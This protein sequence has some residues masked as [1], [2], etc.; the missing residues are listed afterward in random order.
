MTKSK[1]TSKTG[2][3]FDFRMGPE[4]ATLLPSC[5]KIIAMYSVCCCS[6]QVWIS[7]FKK[8]TTSDLF[9]PHPGTATGRIW[10]IHV[11]AYAGSWALHSYQVLFTSIKRFCSKGW[12]YVP[13]HIHALVLTPPPPFLYLNKCIK[14]SLKILQAF[15]SSMQAFFHLQTLKLHKLNVDWTLYRIKIY[16]N[17]ID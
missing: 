4:I 8:G 10:L 11:N 5:F 9:W 1:K 6:V 12:L 13:L 7:F 16:R 14:I 15:K 3:T 17:C 2:Q